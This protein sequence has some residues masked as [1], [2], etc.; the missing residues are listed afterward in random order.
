MCGHAKFGNY[1]CAL[2]TPDDSCCYTYYPITVVIA[3]C[4]QVGRVGGMVL[5]APT[6][7]RPRHSPTVPQLEILSALRKL[8]EE[9]TPEEVHF[10]SANTTDDLRR[11]LQDDFSGERGADRGGEG[12]GLHGCCGDM[13]QGQPA[14]VP[15]AALWE[16]SER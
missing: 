9:L 13:Q 4:R 7:P 5:T 3:G 8:G 12:S 14:E 11:F 1:S 15:A 16:E 6:R 2:S 10:M